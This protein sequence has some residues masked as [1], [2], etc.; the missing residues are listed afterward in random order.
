MTD[1]EL[2][3]LI[4]DVEADTVELT[5]STKDTDKFGEAIC[6]FANDLPDRR[7]AGV[8]VIGLK[9]DR[10]CG[11]LAIT[12]QLLQNLAAIKFDGNLLP[13]PA[14]SVEKRRVR[15]CDVAIVAVQPAHD[16]PI[17]YKGVVWVRVGPRRARATAQDE[18]ILTEKRRYRDQP[19]DLR[20]ISLAELDDIDKELFER[21]YLPASVSSDVLQENERE[22]RHRLSSLRMLSPDGPGVPT[23]AGLLTV[24]RD[25]L[26]FLPGA[27]I[28]FL[29]VDGRELGDPILD[30][31]TIHGPFPLLI[32]Q[33]DGTLKAHNTV[34]SDFTAAETEENVPAYPIVA[35]QQISRN[36]IMHRVYEGTNTPIRITWFND[37]IEILSPGGAYGN[38]TAA[39]FGQPGVTDYRNPHLAEAL[40]NL[41][42]VQRF[43]VGIATA[44]RE[45]RKN[46]NPPVEFTVNANFVLA[47]LR[48]RTA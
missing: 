3:A 23:I 28:Q 27:Y 10:S 30:Q 25:P 12:D 41:G 34:S 33:L 21:V 14:M 13:P 6:A 26:K 40:N 22:Y 18:R 2:E 43:G 4:A 24:G 38:T 46:G 1:Q 15:D 11:G 9:D 5:V 44:Q 32:G 39:N 29:R 47:I 36:A 7:R 17:R 19:F 8:L 48:R 45:M 20:P 37:R 31:K 42:Y 16:T 35:L